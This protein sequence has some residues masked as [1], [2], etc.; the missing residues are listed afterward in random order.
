MSNVV[1]SLLSTDQIRSIPFFSRVN[2]HTPGIMVSETYPDSFDGD[3][4]M[5]P[6]PSWLTAIRRAF[7][8]GIPEFCSSSMNSIWT[9]ST[10]VN[11]IWVLIDESLPITIG[12]LRVYVLLL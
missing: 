2:D 9:T 8:T 11:E 4:E 12:C 7:S 6:N 3:N 1:S 5:L 10:S